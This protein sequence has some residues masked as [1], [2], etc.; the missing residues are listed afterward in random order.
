MRKRRIKNEIAEADLHRQ[1][2]YCGV[3]TQVKT[4]YDKRDQEMA[5]FNLSG[6]NEQIDV[7]CFG[8]HWESV[9]NKIKMGNLV[10]VGVEKQPDKYRGVSYLCLGGGTNVRHLR[11]K[12]TKK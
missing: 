9:K 2:P 11:K 6:V 4:K 3:V 8:S 7:V 10:V 5:F 1:G 12:P